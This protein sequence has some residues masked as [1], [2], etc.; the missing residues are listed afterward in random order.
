MILVRIRSLLYNPKMAGGKMWA[1]IQSFCERAFQSNKKS[2]SHG[3][4]LD[5]KGLDDLILE[6]QKGDP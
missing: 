4:D 1:A 3:K 2:A 6:K 5:R